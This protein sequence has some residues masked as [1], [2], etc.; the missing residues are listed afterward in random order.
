MD[1]DRIEKIIKNDFDE[2]D[3]IFENIE[4]IGVNLDYIVNLVKAI[5]SSC[6]DEFFINDN[7]KIMINNVCSILKK[8]IIDL[9]LSEYA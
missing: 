9:S 4:S 1:L 5:I 6:D 2:R 3:D 7:Y 8:Y